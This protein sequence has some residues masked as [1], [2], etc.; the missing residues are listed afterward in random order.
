MSDLHALNTPKFRSELRKAE[1]RLLQDIALFAAGKRGKRC[2]RPD[3]TYAD[4]SE[5]SLAGLKAQL[6]RIQVARAA[7]AR[8]GPGVKLG[9]R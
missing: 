3:G 4:L 9:Q 5:A 8:G 1:S 6:R 2:R 7:F